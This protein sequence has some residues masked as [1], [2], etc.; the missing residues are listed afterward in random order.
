MSREQAAAVTSRISPVPVICLLSE[1]LY[2]AGTAVNQMHKHANRS[3]SSPAHHWPASQGYSLRTSNR[4]R[5]LSQSERIGP[6]REQ[7]I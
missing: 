7:L 3:F 2:P 1:G 5:R 6:K 4:G